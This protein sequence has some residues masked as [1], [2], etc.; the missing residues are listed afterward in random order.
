MITMEKLYEGKAK[1]LYQT[2]DPDILLT[3]YKD[4][5]TAFNAQ[6]R[7]QIAG[8]GE[9]N[10]TISTALFQ[11]LESLGIP[12]HYIDRPS[13]REMRVKAIKI[14][15]LEVVV[16]NIAAGSLCKQTGLKEGTV[17]P[18]PLVEF[19]LKD[20]ALGDPL[21]TPDRIKVIDIASEEQVNQLRDLALQ[22][23]Q[24]L[25]EFFD[26]CQII[27]VDF[28]LEF[29]VDKTGKIYLG[30]EISPD[31]CRLWDKTQE[32]TQARILDKDRFRR[33]L[34]DV[35]TAYQQV[36]ARVLQQI[37]SL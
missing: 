35:E 12:T 23:N 34:G 32:D 16:R 36:Q 25:Q 28:K 24:Y 17:L 6:K 9:I 30:D 10:C 5:A 21:L 14:I 15:P 22:I 4:D 2:D 31:T 37:K 3:Y 26:K 13:S 20:D 8:K 11:W 1:I 27:L 33:D 7:G 29:G 18:F 19:Y